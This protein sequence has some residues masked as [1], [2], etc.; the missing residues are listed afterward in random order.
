V[1]LAIDEPEAG[2]LRC[3]TSAAKAI[4]EA[5]HAREHRLAE[6]HAADRDAVQTPAQI[7][8]DPGLDRMRV[9]EA[10]QLQIA[11]PSSPSPIQ[12]PRSPLR[13]AWRSSR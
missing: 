12:V 4:L 1:H 13:G 9:A 8:V 2:G 3:S 5:A 11:P 7:A 10:V 6:E